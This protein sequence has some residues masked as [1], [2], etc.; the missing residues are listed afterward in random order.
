MSNHFFWY[1]KG[2]L[3][4]RKPLFDLSVYILKTLDTRKINETILKSSSLKETQ[5]LRHIKLN[6]TNI[7]LSLQEEKGLKTYKVHWTKCYDLF[8]L[9]SFFIA[10]C[11]SFVFL[12]SRYFQF[13]VQYST[14]LFKIL[15][16]TSCHLCPCIKSDIYK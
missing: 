13:L 14:E 6:P 9:F 16:V 8:L 11:P 1:I 3:F 12:N 2:K 5:S 10:T 7:A 15:N 4:L